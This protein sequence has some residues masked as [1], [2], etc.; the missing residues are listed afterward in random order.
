MWL[1]THVCINNSWVIYN[2]YYILYHIHLM[3]FFLFY[4]Q[5]LC[6]CLSILYILLSRP[7][8]GKLEQ[9]YLNFQQVHPQWEGDRGGQGLAERLQCFKNVKYVSFAFFFIY[10]TF[11]NCVQ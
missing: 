7:V 11:T 1:K 4:Y 8:G 6:L 5:H 10:L 2:T 9:S 3:V